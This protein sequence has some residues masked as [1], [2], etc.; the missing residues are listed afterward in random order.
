MIHLA[1]PVLVGALGP[2]L[3]RRL[4]VPI[5]SSYHTNYGAYTRHYGFGVLDRPLTA[6][7]RWIHNQCNVTLCPSSATLA[8]LTE[9]GFCRLA[10][11]GR[12][13]DTA[14]FSPAH[15]SLAWRE[16]V[17]AGPGDVII[18][19]VGRLA[20]EKRLDLLARAADGL[21][22][23]RIVLVGDGPARSLLEQQFAGLPVTFTGFRHGHDLAVA[24]ASADLFVFP[25]DT[26]TFGQVVQE[27]MASG[28]PVL[29]ARA[30]GTRDLVREGETGL[31]FEPGNPTDLR[32]QLDRLLASAD[33]RLALGSAGFRAAQA[34]SWPRV[35]DELL[36]HYQ[37]AMGDA[38]EPALVVS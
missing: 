16:A 31:L 38:R 20:A 13:V 22:A 24:Y 35:L 2:W 15:R 19:Y 5:V 18:L 26:E 30:G 33:W 36:A 3:A 7:L 4:N 12:G 6:Y 14:R 1:G 37:Q 34:R 11:W 29:G 10:L 21:P 23:V 27:A 9:R 28:L 25:S 17:G 8:E 32:A